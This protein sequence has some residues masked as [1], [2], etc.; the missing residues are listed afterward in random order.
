MIG[1]YFCGVVTLPDVDA[2]ADGRRRRRRRGIRPYRRC[3][4]PTHQYGNA[5]VQSLIALWIYG[6]AAAKPYRLTPHGP[7]TTSVAVAALF[8]F[9]I[10][11]L[12][13][14]WRAPRRQPNCPPEH[15]THRPKGAFDGAGSA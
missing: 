15:S 5:G 12:Y 2:A 14:M 11:S 8:S 13:L 3:P 6:I 1:L 9:A 7:V 10:C 4:A